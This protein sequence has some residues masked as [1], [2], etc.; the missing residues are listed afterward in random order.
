MLTPIICSFQSSVLFGQQRK[1]EISILL[2]FWED[3][4]F[5]FPKILGN[6]DLI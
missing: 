5:F 3:K 1:Q 4:E 2:L 6:Y